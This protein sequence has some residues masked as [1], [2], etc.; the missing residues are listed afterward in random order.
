MLG[1]VLFLLVVLVDAAVLVFMIKLLQGDDAAE[2]RQCFWIA[3][4]MAVANAVI[5]AVL[6]PFIGPFALAPV[7]VVDGAILMVFAG[8]TVKQTLATLGVLFLCKLAF[9]GLLSWLVS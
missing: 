5:S 8:L 4:G 7:L 1:L 6:T 3:L 9:T 2:F